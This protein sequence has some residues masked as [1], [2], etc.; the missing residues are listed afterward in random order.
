M[1]QTAAAAPHAG[2][3]CELVL[4]DVVAYHEPAY[5]RSD[6]LL[7]DALLGAAI[8]GVKSDAEAAEVVGRIA[9]REAEEATIFLH[10][11]GSPGLFAYAD[12]LRVQPR[13][14]AARSASESI[15]LPATPS[16]GTAGAASIAK[17]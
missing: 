12:A 8:H 5:Q 3:C 13:R 2:L 4:V 16:P 7:L 6:N 17:R 1:R 15:T 9:A 10:T 14:P 11:G